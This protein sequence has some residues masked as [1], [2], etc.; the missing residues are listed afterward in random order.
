MTL[1]IRFE[2]SGLALALA[3]RLPP[4]RYEFDPVLLSLIAA[5]LV[6]IGGLGISGLLAAAGAGAWG[7]VPALAAAMGALLRGVELMV[8]EVK[9][10]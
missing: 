1:A 4:L 10:E 3:L 6:A 5:L 9:R 7:Q 2:T 8:A